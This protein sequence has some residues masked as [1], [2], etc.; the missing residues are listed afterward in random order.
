MTALVLGLCVSAPA[1]G[2]YPPPPPPV[3][4][5][6][7]VPVVPAPVV[8]A[9][10]LDQFSRV[11]TPVPGKHH[12]W[13]IHPRTCQPV[14]VC[15]TLPDCGKLEQFRV[16]RRSIEFD[17]DKPNREVRIVFRLNGTVDVKYD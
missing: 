17:F 13:L 2:P 7:P 8:Q 10:T 5:P 9:L 4:V 12:V 16:N 11:F 6:A 15:F 14:Q 1:A 3:V